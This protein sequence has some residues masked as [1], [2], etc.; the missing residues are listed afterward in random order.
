MDNSLMNQYNMQNGANN[1]QSGAGGMNMSNLMNNPSMAMNGF[2][3]M[4]GMSG[5]PNI[6]MGINGIPMQN[7]AN[8][9]QELMKINSQLDQELLKLGNK[10]QGISNYT[11]TRSQTTEEL[12]SLISN[13][14]PNRGQMQFPQFMSVDSSSPNNNMNRYISGYQKNA[15][16]NQTKNSPLCIRRETIYIILL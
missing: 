12:S 2:S 5:M 11:P 14:M 15:L 10:A 7:N 3:G 8:K 1:N 4:P 16:A 6:N 9:L 13:Q